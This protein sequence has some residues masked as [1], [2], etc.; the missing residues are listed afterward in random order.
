[1]LE[2]AARNLLELL[3]IMC[4]GPR[5]GATRAC[6]GSGSVSLRVTPQRG[7]WRAPIAP[8]VEPRCAALCLPRGP[9]PA[10][11]GLASGAV[12]CAGSSPSPLPLLS[13]VPEALRRRAC[14]QH[15]LPAPPI[16]QLWAV[17]PRSAPTGVRGP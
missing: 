5:C 10:A 8:C 9:G 15:A 2:A 6:A 12:C 11:G 1:M 13:P 16:E 14:F 17:P 4:A 7:A 3:P